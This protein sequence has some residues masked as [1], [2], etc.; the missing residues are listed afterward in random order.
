MR[1]ANVNIQDEL[2]LRFSTI[3]SNASFEELRTFVLDKTAIRAVHQQIVSLLS[4]AE[5]QDSA[6]AVTALEKTAYDRQVKEDAAEKE[7]DV[8]ARHADELAQSRLLREHETNRLECAGLERELLVN[9]VLV[10]SPGPAQAVVHQHPLSTPVVGTNLHTHM[11][12]FEVKRQLQEKIANLSNRRVDIDLELKRLE[13]QNKAREQRREKRESR[14][15]AR[16]EYAQKSTGIA[17]TLATDNQSR[18]LTDINTKKQEIQKKCSFLIAEAEKLNYSVFLNQLESYLKNHNTRPAQE[19]E[20]LR[21]LLK[22]IRQNLI[23]DK[24]VTVLNA[25]LNKTIDDLVQNQHSLQLTRQRLA[26]LLQENPDLIAENEQLKRDNKELESSQKDHVDTRNS[27]FYNTLIFSG[28]S[29]ICAIPLFLF[30]A[31]VI[32]A[33]APALVIVPPVLL[34]VAGLGLGVATLVY[35]VKGWLDGSSIT[36]NEETISNNK[37]RMLDNSNEI[38]TINN[39]TIPDFEYNIGSL[40]SMQERLRGE[41]KQEEARAADTFRQAQ[42]VRLPIYSGS[43]L[44]NSHGPVTE[45]PLPLV[46]LSGILGPEPSPHLVSPS[47]PYVRL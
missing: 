4:E 3:L 5:K 19:N 12:S 16:V 2:K 42:E 13:Q 6:E 23:H 47:A 26:L 25:R 24:E 11:N 32:V 1:L 10:Q 41:L 30:L 18:L 36:T 21:N 22:L 40:K 27:L 33:V 31:G 37:A 17:A 14:L 8:S 7:R 29:L 20:A 46:S 9:E 43:S 15:Q 35:A 45:G 39:K 38:D 44:F 34:L 28:L